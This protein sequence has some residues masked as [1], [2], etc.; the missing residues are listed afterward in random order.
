MSDHWQETLSFAKNIRREL[1]Q[2]PEL[3]WEEHA[4]AEKIRT[5]LT[6]LGIRW[7]KCAT[8][9]TVAVLNEQ[10]STPAIALRADIDALPINEDT[11]ADWSST[12]S[13]CMHACGHDGHTAVLLATARWLK[14]H[15]NEL[16]RQVILL[17][18]PAEEGG[19]GAREMI[20]E[21]ALEGVSEIYGWHNWPALPYGTMACPD[22][23]IM[24][25]NGTFDIRL[26]GKGGHASQPEV[27]ND[28][29]L[30]GSAI[31]VAMQQVVS[32][33]LPP[34]ANAVVSVTQFNAGNAPTVLADSAT[35]AGSIRV[36]DEATRELV[37]HSI[38]T[39]AENTAAA[40]GVEC[41]VTH[42]GRYQAT[43][44]HPVQ[45]QA[46]RAAWTE[47]YG[48]KALDHGRPMP[49]MASEDF[50]Y[51]LREIPGAFALI[52]SDDGRR[53]PYPCHSPH[54]DFNDRLIEDVCR[55]FCRLTGMR[56]PP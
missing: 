9:G 38:T 43:I 11:D 27:C 28:V 21:G 31:V 48:D 4:T 23:L 29:V 30:A 7:K 17:F 2:R 46:A 14:L 35:I 16:S 25:G 47:L 53:N 24:C 20:R 1:H 26:A 12:S 45:A 34:Q 39:T 22:D 32:R 18:Q 55:W 13:G 56:T 5:V 15:E 6:D 10:G 8:T 44:N 42:H 50:S 49:V 52:G 36:P 37:N 54:Y 3:S 33:R 19:H 51:Y 40:Y 41:Q